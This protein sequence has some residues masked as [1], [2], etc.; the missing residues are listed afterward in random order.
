MI[1][2]EIED[3]AWS[4]ALPEATALV[5]R[6]ATA[7]LGR[8]EGD[9]V[10]LLTDNATVGDLN[11]RFRDKDG[12]TNVLSFPAAEMTIPGHSPHLGDLVLAYGICAEEAAAQGKT[13]SNHL[14]HLTVHG[15]LHL[16]GRDHMAE[17]EAEAMEA[18]ER[19]IL[20]S[21]GVPDPYRP[22][23]GSCSDA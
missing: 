4:A 16:L 3:A 14:S 1:E 11:S 10:V 7:A 8:V 13:L 23:D 17:D 18:E 9:L 6:A 22:D 15:V 21:L 20:A 19:S 2:V 5:E 12:P